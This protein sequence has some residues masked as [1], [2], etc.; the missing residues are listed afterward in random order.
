MALIS[1]LKIFSD[2]QFIDKHFET[3]TFQ[4]NLNSSYLA[5]LLSAHCQK[6]KNRNFVIVEKEKEA[7]AYLFNDLESL[8][9]NIHNL[10]FF[11]S[12]FKKNGKFDEKDKD[13][14]LLRTEVLDKISKNKK[15]FI[16]ITHTESFAEKV[17]KNE[18]L[19][20][21]TF[22]I[23]KSEKLSINFLRDFLIEYGFTPSEFVT[24]PGDF[25]IRG[26]IID[27]FSFSKEMPYRIELFD[28]EVESIRTFNPENQLSIK[29]VDKASII[30]NTDI[31]CEKQ[32]E[33]LIPLVEFIDKGKENNSF[34]TTYIL[35][36]FE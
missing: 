15:P 24:N 27:V 7:A 4:E 26:G 17:I 9:S 19:D 11:N 10:Y 29:V 2:T 12:S 28:D 5:I 20:D 18:D 30:P 21:N 34:E 36:D 35:K 25:S 14:Q 6:E 33:S 8:N 13:F 32:K 31:I 3:A 16:L 1:F 23:K 22:S